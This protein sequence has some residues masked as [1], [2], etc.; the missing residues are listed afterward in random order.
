VDSNATVKILVR[1]R[2]KISHRWIQNK[3]RDEFGGVCA[4]QAIVDSVTELYA[5]SETGP[6]L[7]DRMNAASYLVLD[8][9][10]RLRQ[11]AWFEIPHWNDQPVRVKQDILDVFDEAIRVARGE[12]PSVVVP[13][14]VP[15][16]TD[17]EGWTLGTMV[18]SPPPVEE[19]PVEAV[20]AWGMKIKELVSIS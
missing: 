3:S 14:P 19:V 12:G 6:R 4:G 9:A 1:A 11:G 15:V 8:A 10:K 18:L 13:E 5:P 20:K 2:S 16:T 7:C 17:W